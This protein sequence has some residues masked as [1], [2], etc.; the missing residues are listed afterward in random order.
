LNTSP[1]VRSYPNLTCRAKHGP[2]RE[3]HGCICSF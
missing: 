2:Y 3:V 1:Y